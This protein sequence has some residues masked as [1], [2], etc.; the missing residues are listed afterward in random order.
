MECLD[1]F[2]RVDGEGA[3]E[4]AVDE[5]VAGE[6]GDDAQVWLAG[7]DGAEGDFMGVVDGD[8][9]PGVDGAGVDAGWFA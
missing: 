3:D 2:V 4:A 5:D 1:A 8:V 6:S 7:V 9:A